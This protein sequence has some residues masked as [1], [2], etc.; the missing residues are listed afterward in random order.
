MGENMKIFTP[1]GLILLGVILS[2]IGAYLASTQQTQFEHELRKKS[3]EISGLNRE[4]VNLVTG[5]GSFAFVYPVVEQS[6]QDLVLYIV[7]QGDYP[8]FDAEVQVMRTSMDISDEV[9]AIKKLKASSS[10]ED[11][12]KVVK[13]S[14]R[15][16]NF[17][18]I[19]KA[20]GTIPVNTVR[21]IY[22]I[23]FS[24]AERNYHV[25]LFTRS[26]I[27]E[28]RLTRKDKVD[29]WEITMLKKHE[30]DESITEL[31]DK[32]EAFYAK[33]IRKIQ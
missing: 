12:Q 23:P 14:R 30:N 11:M 6:T 7:Q 22:R 33:S 9:E 2:A 25:K 13:L 17:T 29:E 5:G 4:I 19:L 32:V 3:D 26:G 18:I 27:V 15:I 8:V 28:Q 24:D 1:A 31:N 21:D 20:V 10:P 16:E